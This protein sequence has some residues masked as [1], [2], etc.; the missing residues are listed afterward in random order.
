MKV[1]QIK[2]IY[3]KLETVP[4]NIVFLFKSAC[5]HKVIGRAN[6][7]QGLLEKKKKE[8]QVRV[9]TRFIQFPEHETYLKG[10]VVQK[11]C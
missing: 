3:S 6:T 11:S 9:Y 1:E 2:N 10:S 4:H 8:L 7:K 5:F